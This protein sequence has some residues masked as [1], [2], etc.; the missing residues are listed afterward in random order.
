MSFYRAS[1]ISSGG[2]PFTYNNIVT[3]Q[4]PPVG[5]L[6][7]QD[8]I[9]AKIDHNTVVQSSSDYPVIKNSFNLT[10]L[11]GANPKV[12]TA[13]A[14][15]V[16]TIN[17]VYASDQYGYGALTTLENALNINVNAGDNA[18]AWVITPPARGSQNPGWMLQP[19]N[20]QPIM[21]TNTGSTVG[22]VISNI[23]TTFQA[24][25][26]LML[27]N[28]SGVPGYQDGAFSIVLYKEAHVYIHSLLASPNPA[29]L[30]Q[31]Q[32]TINLSWNTT[33]NMLTLMPGM[34]DVSNKKNYTTQ[35]AE[36]T[37]FTLIAQ[38]VSP[39]NY[40]S[41]DVQVDIFPVINSIVAN[42]QNVYYKDFPH[43]I[44]LDWS[45]NSNDQIV[46]SNSINHTVQDLPPNYTT[47]VNIT[48]PQMFRIVPK[49]SG[50]PL[51][52]ER[53]EVIS[54]FDLKQQSINLSKTAVDIALS[55]TANIC[56]F[57]QQGS[58]QILILET[59]TNTPYGRPISAG[60][61]PVALTFSN[62]GSKLFV[63]N[64]G[65]STLTIFDVAF[66]GGSS[67]YAFT[68]LGS[69]VKLSGVPIA[70]QLSADD[71]LVFVTSNSS[72][73]NPGRLDVVTS[74][75]NNYGIKHKVSFAG[76]VGT[77]AVL[78]SAGQIFVLSQ[79]A[80]SVYVVGYESIHQSYQWVRTIN[81]F[82]STDNLMD[83]AI[84][85][86]DA[87]TLLIVCSGSNCVYAVSKEVT[88]VAGKQN[89]RVGNN[90]TRVLVI[91]SG[92]YAYI[93]NTDD[94]TLSLISCFKGSGLCRILE[95]GLKNMHSPIALTSSAQGSLIYVANSSP[96]LSV[97]NSQTFTP[98]R[99]VLSATLTTSVAASEQHV[100]SWHNYNIQISFQGET[101]TSG[102]SV[103][104]RNTQVYTVV[105]ET[106]KYTTFE[107]WPDSSRN[108]AI[109]TV[110]G[111]N[112]LHVL[113]TTHFS[114]S[115]NIKFSNSNTCRAVATTISPYS[116]I[117]FVL[118]VD[119]GSIYQFMA[120][121]CNQKPLSTILSQ[122]LI[123]SRNQPL[124][125]TALTAVVG[126][127][128][129]A[130]ITDAAFEKLYIVSRTQEGGYSLEST[131]Y[132][133]IYLP[134]AINCAPDDTQL[135][136]W[137]NQGNNSAFARFNIASRTLENFVLP[138]TVSFQIEWYEHFARRFTPLRVRH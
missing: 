104:N 101:P 15:T 88:S 125:A 132:D 113:N 5:T 114:T 108:T 7:L 42:P 103:Y 20:G 73:V 134:R 121:I 39:N 86:Q 123:C 35:I 94:Q 11:P 135:Y 10:F 30:N 96:I 105:N 89:L 70:L 31:G 100:V 78:P 84:A 72:D 8:V 29:I 4:A 91:E 133:F 14:N 107:F 45:V 64:A 90:P 92:A 25:A 137:M 3:L 13:G 112:T 9:A 115:A 40:A 65:D 110:Y 93:A 71:T 16:F 55:P 41:S 77:L 49:N 46:L 34:I 129:S 66:N 37:Q 106:T 80:Q 51:F 95:P 38:G 22:F 18:I 62:D 99:S 124:P 48:E 136:I 117:L 33:S 79:T 44:L 36:S 12:I 109:A 120:V 68:K 126:I 47:G 2:L 116:N 128:S 56:A 69:D 26:T 23:L 1:P 87:G 59:I 53:N 17:F 28:Y 85:G 6:D 75:N 52:I 119:T 21:G 130:F 54:A 58:N 32:A 60:N 19:P 43:D 27:I 82:A 138:S 127:G 74:T 98:Q 63:A 76:Q 67:G 24:G 97:W 122:P 81:G 111:D 131:T 57:I 102:L 61:Q 118:T 50:L 83:I